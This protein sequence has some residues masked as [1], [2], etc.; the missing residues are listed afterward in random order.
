MLNRFKIGPKLFGGFIIVLLLLVVVWQV[1]RMAINQK[2]EMAAKVANAE[3]LITAGLTMQ[4]DILDAM[5]AVNLETI[6]LEKEHA[7]EVRRIAKKIEDEHEKD[8]D[9]IDDEGMKKK[10]RAILNKVR[11]FAATDAKAWDT[12]VVRKKAADKRLELALELV[13][14]VGKMSDAINAVTRDP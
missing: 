3:A 8:F 10:Y 5:N 4:R 6:T 7:D 12:E 14:C 9:L 13:A 11:E 2:T 1:G